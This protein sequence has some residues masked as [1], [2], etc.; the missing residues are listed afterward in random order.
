M[1]DSFLV[2]IPPLPYFLPATKGFVREQ[3]DGIAAANDAHC[4]GYVL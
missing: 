1:A 2:G 4:E 3:L